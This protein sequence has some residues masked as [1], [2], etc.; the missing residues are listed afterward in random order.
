MGKMIFGGDLGEKVKQRGLCTVDGGGSGDTT[1][2][3]PRWIKEPVQLPEAIV[4]SGPVALQQLGS[5]F[6][7][8]CVA[9]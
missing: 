7:V 4:I 3:R 6:S 1:V 2:A 9:I 5:V 8:A